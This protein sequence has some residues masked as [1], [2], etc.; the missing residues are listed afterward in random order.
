MVRA[1]FARRLAV[2]RTAEGDGVSP[3]RE[4]LPI[5]GWLKLYNQIKTRLGAIAVS[6]ADRLANAVEALPD[7]FALWDQHNNLVT[8]N[9]RFREFFGLRDAKLVPGMSRR[10]VMRMG[11]RPVHTT[12]IEKQINQQP[13]STS[14]EVLMPDGRWLHINESA[15]HEGG[16]V[17]VGT[18]ITVLKKSAQ[19]IIE[20]EKELRASVSDLRESRRELERQKQI[21]VELS[22]KYA[23]E[24]NRA[25]AANHAKSEFL[26]NISHELR[27]PL[28]AVIGFSEI[29]Q[30]GLFGNMTEQKYAEYS[31][32]I[33]ESGRFLLEV[34]NDILDM[35]RIEAGKVDLNLE[36][37]DVCVIFEECIRLVS[38][39]ADGKKISLSYQ[40]PE[41][42]VYQ[43]DRRAFKQI[44]LNLLSNAIK[45]TPESGE[46]T[47]VAKHDEDVLSITIEDTGIGIPD[48]EIAKLGR[49]FEQIENQFTKSHTG[50]GLGL[51]ISRSLVELHG[52]ELTI[53]SQIDLGTK[54]MCD[55]PLAEQ[56][57]DQPPE[58]NAA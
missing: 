12:V 42:L 41:K 11:A 1:K 9:A 49:P 46:V 31:K 55:F 3:F 43:L 50:T 6:E 44:V 57:T 34:I 52:G 54:V 35:S 22:E 15:T 40:G 36:K 39:V 16:L 26:A 29:M 21:L 25:E 30:H 58:R 20:N 33:H 23:T 27:T 19:K 38:G 10:S 14:F 53:K 7:S 17:S 24:K 8:C 28:N 48:S 51:A 13:D 37:G 45:F 18:D 2:K 32:D 47:I 56:A 5:G 4:K